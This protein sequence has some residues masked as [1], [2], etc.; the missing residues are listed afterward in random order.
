MGSRPVTWLD[1]DLGETHDEDPALYALADL[2]NLACGGHAGDDA[3]IARSVALAQAAG[4][5][6]G[7]HPS[8][9]DRA[10]FGRN[11]CTLRGAALQ[12]AIA[13]QLDRLHAQSPIAH[14]KPHGALYHDADADPSVQSALFAATEACCGRVP[15]LGPPGLVRAARARGWTGWT[16]GFADRGTR[17][18]GSLLP[19]DRPGAVLTDP[20]AVSARA[21]A[22]R[23]T[24]DAIC[25][26]GDTP[27][28][29]HLAAAVRAA[30]GAR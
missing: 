4:A 10:G 9:P 1:I 14:L 29:V 23:G 21:R 30:L 15:I 27:G 16:E 19:R 2:V 3:S 7:A 12:A 17:P 8:Y 5:R 25:V 6:I 26:H 20:E 18:D 22:L 13:A 28:A 24:V 11:P